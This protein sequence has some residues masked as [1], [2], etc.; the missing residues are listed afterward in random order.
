MPRKRRDVPWL[1]DIDGNDWTPGEPAYVH[2]YDAAKRRTQRL[3]LRTSDAMEAT[4]RYAAFLVEGH[5]IVAGAPRAAKGLTTE[6]AIDDYLREHVATKVVD[7]RRQEA[8]ARHLKLYFGSTPISNIDIPASRAYAEARRLGATDKPKEQRGRGKIGSSDS[9]LRRELVV[10]VA[11]ANHAARWKRIGPNA[12]PPTP[13]PSVELP[14][15]THSEKVKWLTK[16][17]L[18]LAITSA[19]GTLRDWIELA[20][21]TAGRRDSIERLTRFQVDLARGRIDLTSPTETAL[22]RGSKKRRPVVPIDARMRPIVERLMHDNRDSE[23]LF[24]ERLRMYRP[25]SRH[26]K[27][28]GLGHKKNPHILRHSRATHLLNDGVPP[29][30]VAKLLG[31]TM[32]TLE[33]VYGHAIPDELLS[34]LEKVS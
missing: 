5:D 2:W 10:L 31:D 4:K 14:A 25:F 28:I 15:E 3:S 27:A 11:A 9:T 24:G 12:S 8:A 20:Y 23:W 16:E 18:Q 19:H 26:M 7:W 29:F 6:Q 33:R 21:G 32:A 17:E 13:M 22:Q 34:D 30:K 1:G